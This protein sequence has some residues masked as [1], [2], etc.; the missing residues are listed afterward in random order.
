LI[1]QADTTVLLVRR[2][3][4]ED[5]SEDWQ[6]TL[7]WKLDECPQLDREMRGYTIPDHNIKQD[8]VISL[9]LALEAAPKALNPDAGRIMGVIL[10]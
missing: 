5:E 7:K 3:V 9:A 8:C 10:V 2:A 1:G 4:A 6:Q